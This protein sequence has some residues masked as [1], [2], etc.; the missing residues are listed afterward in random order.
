MIETNRHRTNKANSKC[1]ICNKYD[2]DYE[3]LLENAKLQK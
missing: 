1:Q 3:H 2:E